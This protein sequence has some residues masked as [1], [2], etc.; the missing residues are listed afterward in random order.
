MSVACSGRAT[1]PGYPVI[2]SIVGSETYITER[3][4]GEPV[5]W[6]HGNPDTHESWDDLLPLV[7]PGYRHILPD[8]PG[9]G[10]SRAGTS[11][12]FSLDEMAAWVDGV[13][14]A[15]GVSGPV[16]LVGHDF[17]GPYAL[18]WAVKNPDRVGRICLMNT[19]YHSTMRWHFWAR[20]W[21]TPVLGELANRLNNRFLFGRELRRGSPRLTEAQIDRAWS[22]INPHMQDTV[23]RLYRAADPERVVGWEDKARALLPRCRSLVVWGD[24]DPFLPSGMADTFGARRVVHLPDAGHWVQMESAERVAREV[25]AW[26]R[27]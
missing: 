15:S 27:S 5:L 13:L 9:F 24:L 18:S 4:Q 25:N 26:L 14:A 21:R 2:A 8:L 3:G 16:N 12:T 22:A 10:R 11:M 17:G 6:L 19:L 23:L 20:V 7:E 1:S